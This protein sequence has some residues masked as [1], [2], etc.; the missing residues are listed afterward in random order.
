[1]WD[2]MISPLQ[3]MYQ[4]LGFRDSDLKCQSKDS[5][6]LSLGRWRVDVEFINAVVLDNTLSGIFVW[7]GINDVTTFRSQQIAPRISEYI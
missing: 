5:A 2:R 3:F 6:G 4:G 1:M 7:D